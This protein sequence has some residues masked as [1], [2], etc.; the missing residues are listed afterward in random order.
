MNI[1]IQRPCCFIYHSKVVQ[2]T[3][4]QKQRK[5]HNFH[6][7]LQQ[8]NIKH[9]FTEVMIEQHF[10]NPRAL[11]LYLSLTAKHLEA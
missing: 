5:L 3:E 8:S 4:G 10:F 9:N 1:L 6:Q 7:D 11:P 2:T